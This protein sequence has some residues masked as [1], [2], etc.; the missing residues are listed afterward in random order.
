MFFIIFCNCS[1]NNYFRYI[2]TGLLATLKLKMFEIKI[3]FIIFLLS[4]IPLLRS[5]LSW[6][7]LLQLKEYRRDRIKDFLRTKEWK[8]YLLNKR[9]FIYTWL[10][11]LVAVSFTLFRISWSP[12]WLINTHITFGYILWSIY[13]LACLVLWI[14]S[15][16]FI[17][18]LLK[19][20]IKIPK[21][22]FRATLVLLWTFLLQII[23]FLVDYTYSLWWVL[24]LSNIIFAPILLLRCSACV[25]PII[26]YQKKKTY[27]RARQKLAKY[28]NI[29]WVWITWSYGKSS[30]KTIL[31]ELLS[32]EFHT[33]CTPENINTEMWVSNLI[34]NKN[35]LSQTSWPTDL[36]T[37]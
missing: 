37:W 29:I 3:F 18:K 13:F 12:G 34:L 20:S 15:L 14:D 2:Q 6:L 31:N 5:N 35:F 8:H 16:Y 19:K 25:A 33:I 17:Y 21:R 7:Y 24:I 32:A 1:P 22:T 11:I 28:N 10:I 23:L 36:K 26:D 9:F 27:E 30:V 4:L